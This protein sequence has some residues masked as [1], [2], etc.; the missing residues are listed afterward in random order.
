[1]SRGLT[2][3]EFIFF[4]VLC[5]FLSL[6]AFPMYTLY[7]N[8]D[9]KKMAETEMKNAIAPA[10]QHVFEDTGSFPP[11]K[12]GEDPDLASNTDHLAHWQGPYLK[13]WPSGPPGWTPQG[14]SGAYQYRNFYYKEYHSVVL[15]CYGLNKTPETDVTAKQPAQ[16]DDIVIYLLHAKM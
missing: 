8:S 16:G 2:I 1:M 10:L 9:R 5:L 12:M 11:S 7:V 4:L 13:Q 3:T 15:W 6:L 14:G